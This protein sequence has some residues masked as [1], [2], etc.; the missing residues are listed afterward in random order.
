M[1]KTRIY[2]PTKNLLN[3]FWAGCLS[4]RTKNLYMLYIY[5]LW[6]V[7]ELYFW[8]A[9]H[10]LSRRLSA[11]IL[12]L[13]YPVWQMSRTYTE[14]YKRNS[15]L[16]TVGPQITQITIDFVKSL[17]NHAYTRSSNNDPTILIFSKQ[18]QSPYPNTRHFSKKYYPQNSAVCKLQYIRLE[19]SLNWFC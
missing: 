14:C 11:Y 8:N 17:L 12:D 10:F 5:L 2:P 19:S 7:I 3:S 18:K 9:F 13:W 4:I 15:I 16:I 6:N 1:K